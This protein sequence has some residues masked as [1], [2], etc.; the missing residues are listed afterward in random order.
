MASEVNRYRYFCQTESNYVYK[1]DTTKPTTCVNNVAHTIDS[2]SITI[3]DSVAN[4]SV[5]VNNL[6]L[7]AFDELRVAEKTTMF[8]IKS[9]Y[10]KSSYRDTYNVTGSAAISNVLNEG[11]YE[12]YV[13]GANDTAVLTSVERGKYIAGLIGEAGIGVRIPQSLQSNQFI[14]FG[15]YDDSNGF[16]FTFNKDGLNVGR[17][18]AGVD[19]VTSNTDLNIDKLDGN[20][21]SEVVYNPIN[22]YIHDIRFSWYGYGVIEYSISTQTKGGAQTGVLIHRMAVSNETSIS[23]PNLPLRAEIQNN[24][25]SGSNALF[26]SGRQYS[27]IGKYTPSCRPCASY[28]NNVTVNSGVFVPIMS[29]RKKLGYY[30]IPVCIKTADVVVSTTQLVQIR[31]GGTLTGAVWSNVPNQDPTETCIEF[32]STS[33][34]ISGGQVLWTGLMDPNRNTFIEEF[35]LQEAR[36]VS[37]CIQNIGNVGTISTA[38]RWVEEW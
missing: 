14:R 5:S 6:N 13:S 7:S 25:T 3:I 17:R 38:L 35:F 15:L 37:V 22:G 1:W 2:N 11:Q 19:F 8:D 20:G 36:S 33:S 28:V 30:G 32:D 4:Q 23:S 9:F 21:P 27:L 24:G 31:S 10:G 26:I 29:I 16:Y 34:A 12:L 18:K